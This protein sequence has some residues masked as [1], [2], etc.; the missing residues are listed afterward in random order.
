MKKILGLLTVTLICCASVMSQ[1]NY[2]FSTVVTNLVT[3]AHVPKETY[4]F[5]K[6]VK[7]QDKTQT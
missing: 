7:G 1:L 3:S 6:G 5:E 4:I 2:S